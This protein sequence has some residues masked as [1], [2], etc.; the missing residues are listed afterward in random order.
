MYGAII[1]TFGYDRDLKRMT[2]FMGNKVPGVKYFQTSTH[3]SLYNFGSSY[4]V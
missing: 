3:G 2:I 1:S 4:S